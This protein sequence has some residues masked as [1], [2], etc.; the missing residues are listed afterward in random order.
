MQE[1]WGQHCLQMHRAHSDAESLRAGQSGR[2]TWGRES[3]VGFAMGR[4]RLR[5]N[6]AQ[7]GAGV[8]GSGLHPPHL[9]SRG[10]A[11]E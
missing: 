7:D 10:A 11:G 2:A 3:Y 9:G 4:V 5:G 1:H 6:M 8:C